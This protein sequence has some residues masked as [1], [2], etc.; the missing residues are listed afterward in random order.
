MR[1]VRDEDV[2]SA[3]KNVLVMLALR[4]SEDGTG[5]V[6]QRR[7]AA[8]ASLSV[9]TVRRAVAWA[10]TNGWLERTRRGHRL[11]DGR[12]LANE[13]RLVAPSQQ[14]TPV[15]LTPSQQDTDDLLR[16]VSTG[17]RRSST[18]HPWPPKRSSTRGPIKRAPSDDAHTLPEQGHGVPV[19]DGEAIGNNGAKNTTAQDLVGAWIRSHK[20]RPPKSV[21]GQA[22]RHVKALLE[23]G[24]APAVVAAALERQRTKGLNPST[25]P[26]LVNEVANRSDPGAPPD[27]EPD[28]Y[29]I[30]RGVM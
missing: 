7:L 25:L 22:G 15:P 19:H 27:D 23:E 24:F 4:M 21:I 5:W 26:S 16:S 2:S 11:G 30:R 6:A 9:R 17:H 8:D 3:T 1:A 14:D 12:S 13:Y 18:G 10:R 20:V 29:G 28:E